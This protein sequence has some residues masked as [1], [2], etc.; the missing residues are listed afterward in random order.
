MSSKSRLRT[1]TA[2]AAIP[3]FVGTA[4]TADV[5]PVQVSLLSGAQLLSRA[6]WSETTFGTAQSAENA[7]V[8]GDAGPA[9]QIVDPIAPMDQPLT[10]RISGT[11]KGC[12]VT[13]AVYDG[14]PG[15]NWN[16]APVEAWSF[17]VDH[18][19]FDY[20]T[21][22]P[23]F[24]GVNPQ[25]GAGVVTRRVRV[26]PS[27]KQA[28]GHLCTGNAVDTP[29]SFVATGKYQSL[30]S[31][32]Q[33]PAVELH[34]S[35]PG[36]TTRGKD[37]EL[38]L[39]GLGPVSTPV[40]LILSG[41][42]YPSATHSAQVTLA[43]RPSAAAIRS[44]GGTAFPAVIGGETLSLFP[45]LAKL[46]PGHYVF[47]AQVKGSDQ[48]RMHGTLHAQVR[49]EVAPAPP[50]KGAV[51]TSVAPSAPGFFT[52]DPQQLLVSGTHGG[53]GIC[54]SYALQLQAIA[55]GGSPQTLTFTNKALP[56]TL[57]GGS[58]FATLGNGI[59]QAAIKPSGVLCTGTPT[60]ALLQVETPS[61]NFVKDRPALTVTTSV[62]AQAILDIVMPASYG[63]MAAGGVN[64]A[65]CDTE[66]Y[67]QSYSGAWVSSGG[68]V[69]QNY[70]DPVDQDDGTL[71]YQG[72]IPLGAFM[73]NHGAQ[74]GWAL[75]VRATAPGQR[76]AWSN[77]SQ[78][79]IQ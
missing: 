9:Q 5:P 33:G 51:I 77:L 76:F 43:P 12:R 7:L 17:V 66:L 14:G 41:P 25:G 22:A 65:C 34:Q 72:I 26:T 50:P 42:S 4:A 38:V 28:P 79:T 2:L 68:T 46:G 23:T 47:A 37:F 3:I 21:A 44:N 75:R 56:E 29:I 70:G 6:R 27:W 73:Q 60:P 11:G 55:G 10:F 54:D 69:N 52:G 35:W 15:G 64:L 78:F 57:A 71:L 63:T 40:E 74:D 18:F 61:G 53:L 58:D 32:M 39:S 8:P 1:G 31:S 24:F 19:P 16:S 30:I 48:A 13:M 20:T 49:V 59:W 36:P 67:Y 62:G 45:D